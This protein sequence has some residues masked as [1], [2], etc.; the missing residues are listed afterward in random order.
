MTGL[1]LTGNERG[2]LASWS[3]ALFT[4]VGDRPSRRVGT[5][6]AERHDRRAA[7]HWLK[8]IVVEQ[9]DVYTYESI[10][11]IAGERIEWRRSKPR[12]PL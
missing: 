2:C 9:D 6:R 5:N 3:A 8:A 4:R 10:N 7:R 1:C 11:E 12:S